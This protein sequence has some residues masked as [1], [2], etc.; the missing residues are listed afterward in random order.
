MAH[1]TLIAVGEKDLIDK[2]ANHIILV[3]GFLELKGINTF[4]KCKSYILND[5]FVNQIITDFRTNEF[6][7]H[8]MHF[9]TKYAPYREYI[10]KITRY[11]KE[12]DFLLEVNGESYSILDY[13]DNKEI[14]CTRL[15]SIDD[16]CDE[17]FFNQLSPDY[18]KRY[19]PFAVNKK[20]KAALG[21][22]QSGKTYLD[23]KFPNGIPFSL[24]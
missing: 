23:L 18:L 13:Y 1:T 12:L 3:D 2:Y 21:Y 16:I 17:D 20:T 6:S 7:L 5:V 22:T 11:Y 9:E 19:E 10:E 15:F 24:L 14:C 8:V 4:A